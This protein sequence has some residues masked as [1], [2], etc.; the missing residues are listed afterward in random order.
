MFHLTEKLWPT[1]HNPVRSSGIVCLIA[2]SVL[3]ASGFAQ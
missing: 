1:R 3:V 2:F